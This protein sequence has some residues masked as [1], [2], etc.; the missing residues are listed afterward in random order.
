MGQV[1]GV[2][3]AAGVRVE[4]MSG[5]K[6]IEPAALGWVGY[7]GIMERG[8][9]FKLSLCSTATAFRKRHGSII[10][11]GFL[12]D[13]AGDFYSLFNG[14]GGIAAVRVTDGNEVAASITLYARYGS[15][16]TPMGRLDAKNGGRWGGKWKRHTA[17]IASSAAVTNTALTTGVVTWQTDEWKGG[18]IEFTGVANKRYPIVGNTAG[19]VITVAADQTMLGDL[20]AAVAAYPQRYYLVLDNDDKALSV[21]ID[22]GEDDPDGMFS[23]EVFVDGVSVKKYG[24]LHT[25]PEHANY[26]VDIINGD[27]SNDEVVAVDTW[28]GAHTAAVRPANVYG[29][30]SAVTATTLTAVI[31]EFTID[32]SAGGNPTF[33]LGTTTDAHL[34][35][36][37][38]ITMTNA[39]TGTAVSDKYGALG[40]VTLGSLFTPQAKWAP[41]FTVTA[42]ATPLVLDDVLTVVYKPLPPNML[43][44]GMLYPDKV[45]YK[46]GRFRIVA[47]THK[48]ITVSPGS[49]L[50]LT[51]TTSD[52]FM[53]S[54]ALEFIGGR[55]GN[56]DIVDADYEK[57]W[58]VATSPFNELRGKNMGLVKMATPGVTSTAVQKA[59]I[60]YAQA[61]NYQY[62]VEIPSNITTDMDAISYINDTIGRNDRAVAAFPSY[63]YV[64]HPD[65]A[66]ARAGKLKL[67]PLVG[68]IHGRESQMAGGYDGYH[69]AA[70]GLEATLPRLLKTPL[71]DRAMEEESLNPAGI[72]VIV[73]KRGNYVLWGDRTL[74]V[75]SEWRWK[76]QR[77]QMS[78]Y[79]LVLLENFDWIIF[80]INDPITDTLVRTAL[81]NYF[82]PEWTKRAL[83]GNRFEDAAIIKV[84]GELNTD[85]VRA[86]GN[87][88]A[89]V[90]LMLADTTERLI[91][92]IGKQGIFESVG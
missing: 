56:A 75:D 41:P 27:T 37:I 35:Q 26:W 64:P 69:K 25:D 70:A 72:A 22:D 62:R 32:A 82:M 18:Y 15:V 11:D 39:T 4:E 88:V 81:V 60:T 43:V 7:A 86:A 67:V 45:N 3:R 23:L 20:T 54:A 73:K 1:F 83:R 28:T 92:R 38:T 9:P 47:N 30:N 76:H 49:D 74:S 5:A 42:G 6:A 52:Q 78:H 61:R 91:I 87:K 2:T 16:L 31:H 80:A 44:G 34:A 57:V 29:V 89:S 8:E 68:M 53:A 14:A 46:R 24:A 13:V 50:T 21:R 40:T 71:G 17:T 51:T 79:E 55:D 12:P 10:P 36:T 84:D 65:P 63:G 33:A 48:V 77:E 85:A 90:S 66:S 59:G 58:D 19:G